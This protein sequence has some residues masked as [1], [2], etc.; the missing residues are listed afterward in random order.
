MRKTLLTLGLILFVLQ[1]GISQQSDQ[2]TVS[3]GDTASY[4]YW[5][6]MMQDPAANFY[7][8]QR[9]FNLYW[10]NRPITKGCGWKVF[11]RWEYWTQFRVAPDGSR[12]APDAVSKALKNYKGNRS[13]NG[14]W[15][16][17]GP[18]VIPYPGPAG[19]EGIGRINVVAFHPTDQNKLYIGAP[20]GGFWRS[21]DHGVTWTTTT[22][23][24][25]TLGVSAIVVD[26]SNASKILIG[27]G[28]RD[29]GDAPGLGV[30]KSLNGGST[31]TASNTG[32]G[33]QTVG[34]I[35]QDPT[36]A[37]IYLAATSGGVYRSVDGG[38]SWSLSKSG[39]FKDICFKPG[40]HTIV[41]AAYNANF[42]RSSDNGTTFTQ[43]TSGLTSGQRGTIAVTPAN[44]NYV[45]FLQSNSSSG[46]Q[47]LYRSTDAGLNFTARSTSPNI[48]DWSCTGTGSGGQGW[49]D[50]SIAV[51]PTNA[52]VVYVGGIN[53]FKSSNG[54]AT[55]AINAHW[56]G[57]CSVPAVHAD[58]HYL[59]YSPLSGKLYSCNDGGI[60]WTS[61]GGTAWNDITVGLT[62]GQIYK[63]GQ[64]QT[65]KQQVINGHQ[66]NGT[67][68]LY[69]TGWEAT[70]GGDGMECAI[71]FQNSSYMYHTLYYGDIFRT[72]NNG[73][74]TQIGGSGVGGITESG[75]WV[76]PFILSKSDPKV[77]FA[78]YNNIW[79][80]LD[81][82]A[83]SPTWT[84]ISD[85]LGNSNSQN[86]LDL[87]QSPANTQ[88][89]YAS[90]YDNKF[91]RTDNA[92][93]STVTW[94]DLTSLLPTSG[95]PAD[96]A[97]HPTDQNIVYI[98]MGNGVYKS[99][100]KG[101][102][103]TNITGTLPAVSKNAIVYYKNGNPEA[104]YV[105]S[106]AGV[107]YQDQTTGGW[108]LYNT[109][110]P[111]NAIISE[112]EIYYDNDSTSQDVIRA[113]TYGRGLWS[114]DLYTP[115]SADFTADST[116]IC[117]GQ[118]VDFTDLSTGAP[119]AWAWTF[120]GGT[121]SS[122]S[123]QHPQ[124]IVYNTPG[125][126]NVSLTTSYNLTNVSVTKNNYITV[127]PVPASPEQPSGDTLLCMNSSN[128]TYTTVAVSGASSY[129]WNLV[130]DSAGVM[131][132]SDNSV[133]INWSDTYTG[134]ATLSVQASGL[135]GVSSFSPGLTIHLRPFPGAPGTPAGPTQLCQGV[136]SSA[137]TI[138]PTAN[139]NYYSWR[140]QPAGAGTIAG[141]DTTGTVT[142]SPSF[143]GLAEISV[144][145][146]NDCS[147]SSYSTPAQTT[148][149]TNPVVDLGD[150]LILPQSGTVTLDAGNPGAT[151]LWS[152]GATTQTI[153]VGFL[154]NVSDTYWTD[155]TLNDC[156]MSDTI[157]LSFI[158]EGV[159][160]P[161]AC[162]V[163]VSPNPNPGKFRI[164]IS[165]PSGTDL[166]N[167]SLLNLLGSEVFS[168]KNIAISGKY[169]QNMNFSNLPEGL[170]YLIIKTRSNQSVHKVVIQ[171]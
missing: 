33:N 5:I 163:H 24:L 44:P 151:Y 118:N 39:N 18:S 134:Y 147:E 142:W 32:M 63:L 48:L 46:Y 47:G 89:L 13:N 82:K 112:L 160:E 80:C 140:I 73:S 69:P 110:L 125:T 76:T 131:T 81:V 38:S 6:R 154:G 83:S 141:A 72:I 104:L 42:W 9:A 91:F 165:S 8:T 65:V 59:T 49:Y 25:A 166:V 157:V 10:Q 40:D 21:N 102:T 87:E 22:D 61:N 100:N 111:L 51:D 130:P 54:G 150:D 127:N 121:P 58:I 92:L 11:K 103:W 139:T 109:G 16:S 12:P 43:I 30:F 17:L 29:A 119:T 132:P 26:F 115:Y 93:G 71:D 90:R 145:T 126:Y 41:Y 14:N 156:S 75:A 45:Y 84:K 37:Q 159:D 55:W 149:N 70:G 162:Y 120:P 167:I 105:G 36:N 146:V 94:T 144:K 143:T 106:D 88:I 148:I 97:A 129:T 60:Y 56:Y 98:V 122:S 171:R 7:Q 64:S 123:V 168:L 66:D 78:G 79:R 124:N 27:T 67:Y 31:W 53:I 68:T 152:N 52:E 101:Q 34:K 3:T 19:Y 86:L 164:E 128:K 57:G 138:P 15:V 74:E 99:I 133:M 2:S 108:I 50:L 77:M 135:C 155:V 114:S 28:D 158:P 116:T 95:K 1:A 35:I 107:Y 96:I 113:A 137:Y 23:S 85:N 136:I 153:T 161:S 170:Y 169:G 4:P 117:A 62:I 20:S